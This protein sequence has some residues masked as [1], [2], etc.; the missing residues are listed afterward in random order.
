MKILFEDKNLLEMYKM[1]HPDNL[2]YAKFKIGQKVKII[3]KV[4]IRL[5]NLI[6]DILELLNA[7]EL[8]KEEFVIVGMNDCD[9]EIEYA[10]EGYPYLVWEYELRKVD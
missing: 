2:P 1:L 5:N 9:P 6:P 7:Y 10:L 3:K 8:G 4:T